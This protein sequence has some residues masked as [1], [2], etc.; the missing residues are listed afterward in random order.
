MM[1]IVK[2]L[3]SFASEIMD[4]LQMIFELAVIFGGL[5]VY[6]IAFYFAWRIVYFF[7]MVFISFVKAL[8][9]IRN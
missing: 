3:V 8:F 4:V 9:K 2:W 7:L 6:A 1:E 5:Y